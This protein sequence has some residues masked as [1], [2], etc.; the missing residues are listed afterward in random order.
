MTPSRTGKGG[1]GTR[2]TALA[3]AGLLAGGVVSA[4]SGT[5]RTA[6]TWTQ[7]GRSDPARVGLDTFQG[8]PVTLL[9]PAEAL[10]ARPAGSIQLACRDRHSGED[11]RVEMPILGRSVV[12]GGVSLTLST[13]RAIAG[14]PYPIDPLAVAS[15]PAAIIGQRAGRSVIG[16]DPVRLRDLYRDVEG[17]ML[18]TA[19]H[20]YPLPTGNGILDCRFETRGGAA[21][22]ASPDFEILIG[23]GAPDGVYPRDRDRLPPA[24][25]AWWIVD[26]A[27]LPRAVRG[28]I[29]AAEAAPRDDTAVGAVGRPGG[30]TG[31]DAMRHW[32]DGSAVAPWMEVTLDL[33]ATSGLSPARAARALAMVA[34]AANDALLALDSLR[35]T[36]PR[37]D[38]GPGSDD[39]S[40][41]LLD[42]FEH[43]VV[44][45]A[46][47]PVL[48]ELFAAHHDAIE[49]ARRRASEARAL[50]GMSTADQEAGA[51][52]LGRWV[53][54]EVIAR[55]RADGSSASW[56]GEP[57]ADPDRWRSAIPGG[58]PPADPLAGTWR[59]WNLPSPTALRPPGG[60]R[61][62]D[63][64]FER[65][66]RE[67]AFVTS[68]LTSPQEQ[69]ASQWQD[70][71]ASL[72]PPGHWTAIAIHLV[73]REG[74]SSSRTGLLMALLATAQADAFIAA[75]DAKYHYWS[76]RPITAMQAIEPG[77]RPYI[78]T[79]NFPSYVSGHAATS[80]AATAVMG[81]L[82]PH[83][84]KELIACGEQAAESRLLGGIHF[85]A[86]NEAG[87][88][89][90]RQAATLALARVPVDDVPPA[91]IRAGL[92]E[93][94][95]LWAGG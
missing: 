2:I 95:C 44:A 69:I 62:G 84:A 51:L 6:L 78:E 23:R 83:H 52:M 27:S 68:S 36:A 16:L 53:A 41:G 39:A 3:F 59:P 58:A 12:E 72:T 61:P 63:P 70:K 49:A 1:S 80:G 29:A 56:G 46:V 28:L 9:V 47:A 89:M 17:Y 71:D 66:L 55:G 19:G 88:E 86:D 77:W 75:W 67:V 10:V 26:P 25:R 40:G 79:P 81:A 50:A 21:V 91:A 82:F 73:R 60:P 32:D 20:H 92:Q 65:E 7:S 45:A 76:V 94:G 37:A 64:A 34:V 54:G 35:P 87:L 93:V 24:V 38:E 31:A 43:A 57:P 85:R 48:D 11:G 90:G 33:V 42:P 74:W 30:K 14:L 5:D 13:L 22:V 4:A 8:H 18:T 15:K